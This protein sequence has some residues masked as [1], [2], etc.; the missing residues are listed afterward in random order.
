MYL[1]IIIGLA[2]AM[3]APEW[4]NPAE[5]PEFGV[6]LPQ[7]G[8]ILVLVALAGL[9]IT[10]YLQ[11]HRQRLVTDES[12][13]IRRVALLG[14]LYRMLVLAA[15]AYVLFDLGWSALA[16][17]TLQEEGW[18]VLAVGLA[19]GPY[20]AFVLVSWVAVFW[21]DRTLRAALFQRIGALVSVRQWTLSRYLE[22]MLRQYLLVL[23]VPLLVILTTEDVLNHVLGS[24][25]GEPLATLLMV[26]IVVGMMM[27]AGPWVRVCWRTEPLPPGALRDRLNA[28]TER[29]DVRIGNVLVWRTNLSISNGM[30]IGVAGR[31]RYI[32]ITDALLLSMSAQPDEVEAVFAHEVGHAKFRHTA[33]FMALAVGVMAAGMTAGVAAS[34]LLPD[35]WAAALSDAGLPVLAD[36]APAIATFVTAVTLFWFGFGYVSRR[37]EL[38]AD[39][40]AVRATVCPAGCSPPDAGSAAATSGLP[41]RQA[42][43]A[44]SSVPLTAPVG[45]C[46][47][48]VAAFTGALQRICR[49]NGMPEN[50]RGWRHFSVA[51][52]SLIL[53]GLVADPSGLAHLERHIRLTK[54]VALAVALA[55]VALAA[56]VVP[57]SLNSESDHPQHPARPQDI[58]PQR[59][60]WYVRLVDGNEVDVLALRTPELDGHAHTAA[61]LDD[62]RLAGLRRDVAPADDEVAVQDAR[63]HA[64]TVDTQGE[65]SGAGV[66]Q[67]GE[68]KVLGDAVGGGRG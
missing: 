30:M 57:A 18:N 49:L 39:L 36:A 10:A 29:A 47:H 60:T 16:A 6:I 46:E 33:L 54:N 11:G 1:Y 51:H 44:V 7:I 37:C 38:E 66:R 61:Q 63:G 42:G 9:G 32:M 15:Y 5:P 19:L 2:M 43:L 27:L 34:G 4:S 28:L 17:Q 64:V 67:A 41:V 20:L 3:L 24:P 31:L 8:A 56:A 59:P 12:G 62:G 22:F 55:L 50:R 26:C 68:F 14:R 21:A 53:A 23:L 25:D 52:R 45:F 58:D 40:Y 13:F 48:R 65:R 35:S